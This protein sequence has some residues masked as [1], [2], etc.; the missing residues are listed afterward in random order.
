M[1]N[2]F[3]RCAILFM[4]LVVVFSMC[5]CGRKI[6]VVNGSKCGT[7][8]VTLTSGKDVGKK[9]TA[10]LTGDFPTTNNELNYHYLTCKN[11]PYKYK[12]SDNKITFTRT[13][14]S[15]PDV[16]VGSYDGNGTFTVYNVKY[17]QNFML[18]AN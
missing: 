16:I 6:T 1:K 15:G 11:T 4:A 7:F 12:V 13:G 10:K 2:I 17:C 9:G 14:G 18:G 5:G 3:K 8:T